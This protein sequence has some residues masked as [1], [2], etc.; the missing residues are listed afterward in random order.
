MRSYLF[1]IAALVTSVATAQDASSLAGEWTAKY[2]GRNGRPI[3]AEVSIS[4]SGGSWQSLSRST[5]NPC[6]GKKFPLLVASQGAD[7]VTLTVKASEV[8]AGCSDH[9]LDLKRIDAK[10]LEGTFATGTKVVLSR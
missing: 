7:A 8:I 5:E 6:N 10:T 1:A 9:V 2:V 4:G 3:Q